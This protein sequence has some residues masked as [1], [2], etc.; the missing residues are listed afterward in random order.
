LSYV[1]ETT[2]ALQTVGIDQNAI[3]EITHELYIG[4]VLPEVDEL[5]SE[6]KDSGFVKSLY[7]DFAKDPRTVIQSFLV[8]GFGEAIHLP[9]YLSI[10]GAIVSES[11]TRISAKRMAANRLKSNRLYLLHELGKIISHG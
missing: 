4:K 3:T 8:F 2:L 10:S 9:E 5:N 11:F 6:I 1:A 7:N